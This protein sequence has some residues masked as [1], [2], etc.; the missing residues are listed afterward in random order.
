MA[1]RSTS[2]KGTPERGSTAGTK[3]SGN[4]SVESKARLGAMLQIVREG[5]PLAIQSL[6]TDLR[7]DGHIVLAAEIDGIDEVE[8][9]SDRELD[10]EFELVDEDNATIEAIDGSSTD[11][12]VAFSLGQHTMES[13]WSA[14]I[15]SG[16]R[17][18]VYGDSCRLH[19]P[20]WAGGF[21]PRSKSGQRVLD[22]LANRFIVLGRVADWLSQ[23][24]KR[25]LSSAD[26]WD[27]GGDALREMRSGQVPVSPR[28]FLEL[29]GIGKLVKAETFSRYTR[30]CF[31]LWPDATAPLS[32]LFDLRARLAWVGNVI[33]QLVEEQGRTLD[34]VDLDKLRK[35]TK[36][37][38]QTEK[39]KLHAASVDSLSF[40]EVP[41]KATVMANVGWSD[42]IAECGNRMTTGEK[43]LRKPRRS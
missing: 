2:T 5:S 36:P 12:E 21:E 19:L 17:I 25:F 29:T 26:P 9:F 40:T 30:E 15:E 1:P 38:T 7:A 3:L 22:E 31:L 20:S 24:R 18:I 4:A 32:I 14:V 41:M 23:S 8:F 37:R 42:V 33:R 43:W 34:A 39:Q 11:L 16:L 28:S 35:L 13:E 6:L 27:L 10:S